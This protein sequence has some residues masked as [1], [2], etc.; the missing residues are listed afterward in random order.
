VVLALDVL[1]LVVAPRA[2]DRERL[3]SRWG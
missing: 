3:M 2:F 1:L